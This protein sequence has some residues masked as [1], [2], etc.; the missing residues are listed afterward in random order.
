MRGVLFCGVDICTVHSFW[1]GEEFPQGAR[2]SLDVEEWKSC[3]GTLGSCY[4]WPL[5][6]YVVHIMAAKGRVYQAAVPGNSG[7]RG[8]QLYFMVKTTYSINLVY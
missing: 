6:I 8:M 5:Q 7:Q 3:L 2:A 4:C 1:V